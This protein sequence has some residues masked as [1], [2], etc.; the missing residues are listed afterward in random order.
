MLDVPILS[1]GNLLES[2]K[3]IILEPNFLCPLRHANGLMQ[4]EG[5]HIYPNFID[6]QA[7]FQGK[8]LLGLKGK[9][10]I[11]A[12]T[13]D[14]LT[15]IR[16]PEFILPDIVYDMAER[17]RD[18]RRIHIDLCENR[19]RLENIEYWDNGTINTAYSNHHTDRLMEL[20]R[21]H[22][23]PILTESRRMQALVGARNQV[24]GFVDGNAPQV[25]FYD[26]HMGVLEY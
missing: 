20:S 22:Q 13:Y 23:A 12:R 16:D 18:R 21:I 5:G 10:N 25:I 4:R 1:L 2:S 14:I 26:R 17:R 19:I 7:V 24:E 6:A 8:T 11:E 15:G 3:A 9:S